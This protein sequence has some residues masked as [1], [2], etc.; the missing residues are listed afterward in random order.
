MRNN[1]KF[2][3]N[4]LKVQGFGVAFIE[5]ALEYFR[6][7][8]EERDVQELKS[9]ERVLYSYNEVG[10]YT[11]SI[12]QS[13][14]NLKDLREDIA[15]LKYECPELNLDLYFTDIEHFEMQILFI[16]FNEFYPQ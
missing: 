15:L 5:K 12:L 10:S 14:D 6:E 16:L 9:I 7:L 3:E 2:F 13:E 8:E 4:N 11:C 1:M